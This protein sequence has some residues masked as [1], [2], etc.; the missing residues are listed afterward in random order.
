MFSWNVDRTCEWLSSVGFGHLS[1]RFADEEID[2]PKL[3]SMDQAFIRDVLEV[4]DEEADGLWNLVKTVQTVCSEMS[5]PMSC[6]SLGSSCS[7]LDGSI[8]T[9]GTARSLS[10]SKS[11]DSGDVEPCCRQESASALAREWC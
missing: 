4:H 6:V 7:S 3:M 1:E 5:G 8:L 2:G 10:P 9:E 11:K